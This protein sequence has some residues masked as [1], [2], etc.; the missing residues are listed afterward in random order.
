MFQRVEVDAKVA[1]EDR[2]SFSQLQRLTVGAQV[3]AANKV[4]IQPSAPRFL[5]TASSMRICGS[6]CQA[7]I[8]AS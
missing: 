5:V 4:A 1:H 3:A 8:F 7:D 6:P 2:A